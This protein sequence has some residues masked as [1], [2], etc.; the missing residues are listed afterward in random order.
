MKVLQL[1]NVTKAYPRSARD[2]IAVSSVSMT[3]S[4]GSFFVLA[5]ESGSGKST[6]LRLIAGLEQPTEGEIWIHDHLVANPREFVPPERRGV[7]M[8]FQDH[9]LFPHLSV[10]K[11][12]AY[13]L[14]RRRSRKSR[15]RVEEL[16][17][18]VGLRGF[19][20][21][22]PHTLSG[23]E[24][25]RVALARALAP[26]PALL[27]LDEPFCNLDGSLRDDLRRDVRQLLRE[28]GTTAILVT[29]DPEEALSLG[30]EVGAVHRGTLQQ[31]GNPREVYGQPATR[32]VANLF[33]RTNLLFGE[34]TGRELATPLG[35][36]PSS[37]K[38]D[39]HVLVSVRPDR[40]RFVDGASGTEG[41]VVDHR[42]LG[43]RYLTRIRV[44]P[45]DVW[46]EGP[47]S[48]LTIGQSVR[49]QVEKSDLV[50]LKDL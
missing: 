29:H 31:I 16:L 20:K 30:D 28:S 48:D 40:I 13:G 24:Q 33:G 2:R 21:R 22:M 18:R 37:S 4:K 3:I 36:F 17:E 35:K 15:D 42:F 26:D 38:P 50:V 41:T 7:G 25:Q 1:R 34:R 27:L 47:R 8:V 45:V 14:S 39:S 32:A 9:A 23:G 5:G 19:S 46:V 10:G 11:N 43:S 49:V 6:I 12:V 44:G